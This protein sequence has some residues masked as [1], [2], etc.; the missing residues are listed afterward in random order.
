[1]GKVTFGSFFLVWALLFSGCKD[2]DIK[3]K[4]SA[5]RPTTLVRF[6]ALPETI[7]SPQGNPMTPEKVE[8]GRLLFYDPILSG[9]KDVACAT[10]HHPNTGYAE[11]LDISMGANAHGLGSKRRFNVPNDIP[12]VKR[13]AQTII[14]TAFN[15]MDV[16]NSYTPVNAPMFWD[17]RI[18][19]LEKQA[20]E[21]IKALEEMR[22]HAHSE[23]GILEVIVER[24]KGIPEYQ[25]LFRLSFEENDAISTE[26]LGK[27]IAAFERSLVT[28]NSRF[29]QYMRGDRKAILISEQEGF[30]LFQK[31]GCANCHNGPMFSDYKP[32][33]L[34]A[35]ENGKLSAPDTGIGDSFAFRTPTLRNLRFTAPYMHNG[36]LKSLKRVL[37]FYEDIANGK[38]R[39]PHVSKEKFDPFVRE[40]KLSVK[41]MSLII[42]F[43]N[44]LNDDSFD[45]EIPQSVP[46]GLPVGGNIHEID[47]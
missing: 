29:D 12:F 13:N 45:K 7:K 32:H 36:S 21:P 16:F 28:N 40:L 22:G 24:L 41:E 42:S 3:E 34:G 17:D 38:E 31:V 46:S 1:M 43:L 11:F 30:E 20:L 39:N 4:R 44:T 10:C 26:N 6:V 47:S 9:N 19:S 5:E 37:E 23:E 15:G 33:V 14:N 2:A 8:L 25:R 35:P 18:R 27:A